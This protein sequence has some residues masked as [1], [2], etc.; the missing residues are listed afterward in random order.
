MADANTTLYQ[1][2][3]PEVGASADTW[4]AK[5]NTDL[6]DLDALSGAFTLTGSSSAYVLTTGLSLAAYVANQRFLVKW[7]H[8]NGTTPTLAVDGLAAK[9]IKKRDASTNPSASDLVSG[10]FAFVAYDGTNF[11]LLTPV[12]SDFQAKD[13][14]LDAIS[15]LSWSSGN[16][17]V[18]FTA[19]DTVSLT[20]TPSVSSVTASQGAANT[21]PSGTF[22]N[23]TN[24]AAVQALR[25]GGARATGAAND[26]T[27]QSAYLSSNTG[28]AREAG[29]ITAQLWDVTNAAEYGAMLFGVMS[30]GTLTNFLYMNQFEL[31]PNSND[32]LPLGSTSRKWSDLF[33]ASG[34]VLNFSSGNYTLTHSSGALEASGTFRGRMP[35]SS[36]TGGALTSASANKKVVLATAPS[37]AQN[38]FTADDSMVLVNDTS[39]SMTLT[40]TS[41]TQRQ[42]GT[43]TTGNLTIPPY[44][45]LVVDFTTATEWIVSGT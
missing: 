25:W 31:S 14:T 10:A 40:Q 16:P 19:A 20:L 24:N 44:G 43:T 22:T 39:S 21:T 34:A 9:S 15:A 7:N 2:V 41:G 28:V 33:L 32:G 18:Q 35:R 26:I 3:K 4:G 30:A 45:E 38:V 37:I 11:V 36:E 17:L 42:A 12:A 8:T 27:Y 29:R 1:F 5:L 23:T 13:A 6:D